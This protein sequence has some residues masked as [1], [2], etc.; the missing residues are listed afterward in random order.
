MYIELSA[1]IP[2]ITIGR[3]AC[4]C[5]RASR[6]RPIFSPEVLPA[7]VR[8]RFSHKN[9]TPLKSAVKLNE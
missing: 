2:D 4:C 8:A 1:Q 6:A 7:H 3:S 9:N 5:L